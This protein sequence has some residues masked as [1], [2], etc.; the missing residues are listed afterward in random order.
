MNDYWVYVGTFTRSASGQHRNEGIYLYRLNSSTGAMT[1]VAAESAGP[2]P[3]FLTLDPHRRFLYTVNEV[4][5]FEGQPG[6]AVSAFSVDPHRGRLTALNHQLTYGAGPCYL[7][8]DP[9]ARWALVSNYHGGSVTVLPIREGGSLG[10][11]TQFIQQH[12]SGPN[13]ERQESAHA[14]SI[15]LDPTGR[16]ALVADLGLD[17]IMLYRFDAAQGTLTPHDPPFIPFHPGAGPRHFDFHPNGRFLYV[18]NELDST[19]TALAYDALHDTFREL[20]TLSSLPG[21][22]VGENTGA[23]IHIAPSGKFLYASNR[24][25]DSIAMYAVDDDTGTL[26]PT[27]H[28]S[29]QG[30]VPRNFAIAP[31]GDLILAANQRSDNVVAFRVDGATGQLAPLGPVASIPAPVCVKIVEL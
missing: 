14:H 25:H 26:S 28:V 19:V 9:T 1:F 12:G 17:K 4:V 18:A 30:A 8:L 11:A 24:G 16:L 27:G 6:G 29:T 10:E 3:G 20:Q 22:F 2:D 21:D 5:E 7:C 23:D 15:Q 31:A 13:L